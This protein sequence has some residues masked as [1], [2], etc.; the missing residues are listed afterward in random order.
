MNI[1]TVL[2]GK[3]LTIF[4]GSIAFFGGVFHLYTGG[5]GTFSSMVQTVTHW[6]IIFSI[7]FLIFPKKRERKIIDWVLTV[8]AIVVGIYILLT[9]KG[10][11]NRLSPILCSS[12]IIFGVTLVL[13]V[14]EASRRCTGS[15]LAVTALVLII[16]SKVG[17]YLPGIFKHK[18]YSWHR[19]LSTLSYSETGIFGNA[20]SI[21]ATFVVLFVLF[22]AF[23][24]S[25]NGGK[26][27][28]DIAYSLTGSSRGGPAKTAILSSLMLGTISGSPVANVVTTGTFTIPLMKTA[29]YASEEACAIEAVASTGGQIMPP[30]M[31][32]AAFLVAE[33][34][35]ISYG[36][37]C[38]SAF[39]PAILFYIALFFITDLISLKKGLLGLPKNELPVIR[40]SL[41]AGGHLF[42]PII[43]LI[44]SLVNGF[45]S[46][47][48]VFY[49]I[50]VLIVVAFFRKDTRMTLAKIAEALIDGIRST[51]P[52]AVSCA[53][54][55]I[56]VGIV[57]LTGLGVK[58]SSSLVS[59]S[60]GY[61]PVAL[62]LTMIAALILG[63]GLP[64][65]AVYIILASLAAPA[66]VQMGITPLAA[67]LFVFYFGCISTITPP[68]ALTSYAAAGIGD[69]DP[70]K[71]GFR[72]FTYGIVAYIVPFM[73]VFSPAL[74]LKGTPFRITLSL[75]TALIGIFVLSTAVAGYFKTTMKAPLR[76]LAFA[77]G[78][79]LIHGGISTDLAGVG[80]F[81][82]ILVLQTLKSKKDALLLNNERS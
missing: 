45:S 43:V 61:I 5:I 46:M 76:L 53:A 2:N 60:G 34:I 56:I 3:L 66:L 22:G 9:W 19:V 7:V 32:A 77:S 69:A 8:A 16:Y 27:F 25:S 1:K 79:F 26:L 57:N 64:T 67:H 55:G 21:S 11:V 59:L 63:S 74:L 81:A 13:L 18:G 52:V 58:F 40:D 42:I 41:L 72:A 12:E 50:L 39:V 30:V 38:V 75:I 65:T 70:T 36:E 14:L 17:P 51:V 68:V 49:S 4:V 71:T 23:L 10:R 47:K 31:G 44:V 15:S 24:N 35:G 62:F 80:I 20:L 78:V 54:A 6:L 73:F 37:L 29:G 82:I 33:Y 28:I 48:S